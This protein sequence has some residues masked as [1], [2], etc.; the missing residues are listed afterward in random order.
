[1]QIYAEC[2]ARSHIASMQFHTPKP[3][4]NDLAAL[5]AVPEA[6]KQKF[7][8]E[9][10]NASVVAIRPNTGE[11]LVMVGSLDYFDEAIDGQVNVGPWPP[12]S[13]VHPSSPTPT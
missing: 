7:D 10:S 3:C 8:H 2:V 11:V 9:V 12:A 13:P 6:L 5:P 4:Q 1:M